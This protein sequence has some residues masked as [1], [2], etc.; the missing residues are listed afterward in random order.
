MTYAKS[1]SMFVAELGCTRMFNIGLIPF[2][3]SEYFQN[4]QLYFGSLTP[5]AQYFPK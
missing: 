4:L 1:R 3:H 2:P 5:L